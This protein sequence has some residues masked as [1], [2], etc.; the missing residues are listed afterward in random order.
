MSG[1]VLI[2][3]T[4]METR[5]AVVENGVLQEAL[6]ERTRRRGIVGNIYKGRVV[7]VLPGM[8]AAFVDIGLDRAAFIHVHEVMPPGTPSEEQVAIGQ[9]LSEGQSLVVQVTKDPIG[10]KGARLTTH[11]SVP[12]RY[13]V[14]MPDSPHHGV[15]QRIE[16][17]RERE[18]LREL[19]ER[20]QLEQDIEVTGGFIVRT[21]AENVGQEE[22]FADMHFLL[23]L[24]R[25]VSE[26]KVSAPSPSVIYDDLPLFIRTLRDLMRDDIEKV[27]ID[28]RENY[29]KLI[30]FAEEFMP[31]SSARIEY[32]PGERPIFDL[33]SVEDEII[34]ALGRKVQLK[35]GG[36]LVIDPTE[37]MTT[38]DVNTGGYV[39]HR[40]L[41]ETIFKTNLEAANAIARQLRLRNLGGIIIID[42][43]DMEETEHQRQVLRVLEKALERDHAKTKCTGVTELGLVQLTR[44]RTRESLEQTLCEACPT[45]G[46]RGTLKTAETV[47][48]EIFREILREER[49][50]SA[51]TYMVLA[52]QSVV[53]R[54]LDEESAAVA[55]L[56]TFIGK[57]IRFQVENHYSQEQY[58]IVLM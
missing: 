16:D 42:F 38:I 57:T 52:S 9:L 10:S 49:A 53:D 39:G 33:Y 7:R 23:R 25:K 12:S 14:Y 29:V 45:C 5:V 4:P 54:L 47:C 40:N 22:L 43:I 13:L 56:E 17:E 28:S 21:A 2:N 51:E 35:S 27:R 15:S 30:E 26:R 8:Q 58:D 11:L 55:D 20:C 41:E 37:A 50:Y 36:Y 18:R 31:D 34:K 1:E 24:W 48:Y 3:L 46:G 44:K 32:Y 19:L 6:I